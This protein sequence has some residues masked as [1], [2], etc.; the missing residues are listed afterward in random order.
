MHEEVLTSTFYA[1]RFNVAKHLQGLGFRQ[2]FLG[3]DTANNDAVMISYDK[4]P[5]HTT[6][7]GFVAATGARTPGV[8]DLL[9]AGTTDDD[10]SSYWAVIERVVA[11]TR[12]LPS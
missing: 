6:I 4:L 11:K 9:F 3:V 5:K 10:G 1:G 8:L 12:W 2:L 7:G